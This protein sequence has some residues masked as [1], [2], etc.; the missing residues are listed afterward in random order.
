MGMG[1]GL[2]MVM[3]CS[4]DGRGTP[5]DGVNLRKQQLPLPLPWRVMTKIH[6]W[7]K[8]R[9]C[10]G[11]PIHKVARFHSRFQIEIQL[12]LKAVSGKY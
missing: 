12:I 6:N 5:D 3:G 11:C 9:T 2:E 8:K 4:D 7:I 10:A 1:M